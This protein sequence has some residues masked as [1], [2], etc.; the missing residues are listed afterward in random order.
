MAAREPSGGRGRGTRSRGAS[1]PGPRRAGLRLAGRLPTGRWL[2][3]SDY[4]NVEA[5]VSAQRLPEDVRR[6]ARA[7]S[8]RGGP[9]SRSRDE[10]PLA[11]G[12][13]LAGRVVPR[14]EHL[15]L[16][17]H[18]GSTV[19]QADAPRSRDL[20]DSA[21][22]RREGA[23]RVDPESDET[24]RASTCRSPR[25]AS[26]SSRAVEGG[27]VAGADERRGCSRCPVP[28]FGAV[29]AG[30]VARVGTAAGAPVVDD[31]LDRAAKIPSLDRAFDLR[32]RLP[33]EGS[34]SSARG[35]CPRRGSARRSS[36][37][38]EI[39]SG[40]GRRAAP[41]R[42]ARGVAVQPL[43]GRGAV[44]PDA[45]EA[46]DLALARHVPRGDSPAS[47]AAWRLLACATSSRR[48]STA[49]VCG[50][51]T[52][53]SASGRRGRGGQRAVAAPRLPREA[54]HPRPSADRAEIGAAAR[55]LPGPPPPSGAPPR[56][57]EGGQR[58]DVHRS[59]GGESP[60]T[61]GRRSSSFEGLD[62]ASP[63]PGRLIIAGLHG[64]SSMALRDPASREWG[65][66]PGEATFRLP[67]PIRPD[68]PR[69]SGAAGGGPRGGSRGAATA[70]C[71]GDL[72][73]P[74]GGTRPRPSRRP[75]A[76]EERREEVAQAR[77]RHA[78][79]DAGELSPRHVPGEREVG[80]LPRRPG[81]RSATAERPGTPTRGGFAMALRA[82]AS[83]ETISSSRNCVERTDAG[84]A[85]R[86][87]RWNAS[88]G[89]VASRS[90]GA[91]RVEEDLRRAVDRSSTTG[92][93]AAVPT[94]ATT[95]AR[96]A[97]EPGD[98]ISSSHRLSS[99]PRTPPPSTARE[100]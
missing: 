100:A 34:A 51:T 50:R 12:R 16:V 46:A 21:G 54:L 8:G 63:R 74:L 69:A 37:S 56:I 98:G 32:R 80:R 49:E 2:S 39:V 48:S 36:A 15:S 83:P 91:D 22:A 9:T 30:V 66:G 99:A 25:G 19:V 31:R 43:R 70:R 10:P 71:R 42:A 82:V 3:Y 35:S 90:K 44:R 58:G 11:A 77:S 5:I 17:T 14:D 27:G 24:P 75:R 89:I 88:G 85:A 86:G 1:G 68:P 6:A 7:P 53:S 28:G 20:M 59:C 61:A 57:P 29:L 52:P 60:A 97:P 92:A 67:E 26:G 47:T 23:G 81:G 72:V 87:T 93:P 62:A 76:L 65:G 64:R 94:R 40:L 4:V 13:P 33:P 96:T 79:V 38:I 84:T 73:D 18:Q 45:R 41:W 78:A 55:R 95:P